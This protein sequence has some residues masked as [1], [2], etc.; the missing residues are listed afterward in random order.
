V[1]K[2]EQ[3]A[4][5]LNIVHYRHNYRRREMMTDQ[6]QRYL[7]LIIMKLMKS[8]KLMKLRYKSGLQVI[9]VN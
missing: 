6:A 4:F 1:S 3:V 2:S 5:E 7:I 8:M 9:K